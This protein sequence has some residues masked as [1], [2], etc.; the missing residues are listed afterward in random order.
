MNGKDGFTTGELLL[1]LLLFSLFIP[2]EAKELLI[3]L[4]ELVLLSTIEKTGNCQEVNPYMSVC[5]EAPHSE[6]FFQIKIHEK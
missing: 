3:S 2:L 6:F 5:F 1:C 4:R